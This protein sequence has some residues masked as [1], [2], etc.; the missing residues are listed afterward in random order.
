MDSEQLIRQVATELFYER[1]FMGTS[2]RDIA[3]RVGMKAGSL[4]NHF[5]GK[6][7]LLFRIVHDTTRDFLEGALAAVD[8]LADPE[9]L[10]RALLEWHVVFH[11]RRRRE[12][13]VADIELRALDEEQR[14][15]V[16][17]L[18]DRYETLLRDVLRAGE[19]A[20]GWSIPD[21]SVVSI[22]I[23][24]M[25]TEVA[26]W[27]REDGRLSPEEIGWI[28]AD[29]IVAGLRGHRTARIAKGSTGSRAVRKRG[30]IAGA[31]VSA[32]PTTRV[33]KS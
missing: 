32:N 24:T 23:E 2:M 9:D 26:A 28:F 12:A 17:Q 29:F 11:A 10:L 7:E 31:G 15:A 30:A 33:R 14:R 13:K 22:G 3:A 27:Y 21:L 5:T 25:C 20:H 16:V 6:R 18:R 8:Q 1:G 19:A 4:Y